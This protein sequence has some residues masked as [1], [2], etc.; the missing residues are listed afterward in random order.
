M[1]R[2][3]TTADIDAVLKLGI[4][5]HAHSV[6][7]RVPVDQVQSRRTIA[8][9]IQSPARFSMVK[10]VNGEVLGV[11]LGGL[12]PIWFN[13]AF[14]EGSDL[15][16]YVRQDP[17]SVGAGRLLLK[18][19]MQWGLA[20]NAARFVMAVSVGGIGARRTGKLYEKEGFIQIGGLYY[21][22]REAA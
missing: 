19:F 7:R 12:E 15:L 20:R 2:E 14:K 6:S 3:A 13:A 22:D 17:R 4:E 16:F 5:C 10:E 9:F 11:L 1:I 8:Q 21:W 18:R